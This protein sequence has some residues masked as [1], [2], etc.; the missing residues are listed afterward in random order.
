MIDWK[1]RKYIDDPYCVHFE[2]EIVERTDTPSGPAVV[3]S[4]TYFY[5]ESGGQPHDL[6]TIGDRRLVDVQQRPD[7][8]AVIHTL[9]SMPATDHVACRIDW[10]RRLDHMQQHSG[11]HMLS[12]AFLSAHEAQTSSFHLGSAYS[13]ID[14][15]RT[16]EADECSVAEELVNDVIRKGVTIRSRFAT[17]RDELALRKP[18][19]AGETLR[20]VTVDGL[21]EQACCGT[22]PRSAAEVGVVMVRTVENYKGGSRVHFVC[23][24][25][26]R[27]D[28]HQTIAH[29]RATAAELSSSESDAATNVNRLIA[30]S[31]QA[32]KE[33]NLLRTEL[34][35]HRADSWLDECVD[36][37]GA[38][39]LAKQIE[40]E[41]LG[42]PSALRAA[43]VHLVREP[44]R[45][46]LLGTI[47][48]GRAHLVF[49][50]S[51][52]APGDMGGLLRSV[53]S[54]VGG[55]GGGS[56]ELAQGG[57]PEISGLG[58]AIAA[59]SATLASG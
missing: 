29:L 32:R 49:A 15:D 36:V 42:D 28:Y 56:G 47:A 20:I 13:T 40:I 54:H 45:V 35:R 31:K 41:K 3:L 14:L 10:P 52:D 59:A 51:S 2:A 4:Q 19:P 27:R 12:A 39:V 55:K 9:E 34:A 25:R 11:Q 8:G 24:D 46:V 5:P 18:P 57:G 22:H 44:N 50:R 48:D 33:L 38:R 21:D 58:E 6:G 17:D 1:A 53:V 37:A 30:E 23:G 26:A 7:D 43:A 16:V